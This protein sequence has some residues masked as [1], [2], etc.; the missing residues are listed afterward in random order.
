MKKFLFYILIC[1]IGLHTELI[2][3]KTDNKATK[4]PVLT[5]KYRLKKRVEPFEGAKSKGA[6][7]KPTQRTVVEGV[8]KGEKRY[9]QVP[10]VT[11]QST[12]LSKTPIQPYEKRKGYDKFISNYKFKPYEKRKGYDEF[13]S[14]YKFK[15]YEKR[16]G[17]DKFISNYKFKPYEKRRG[18]DK[19]ISNYKFKPYEKRRG[20]DKFTGKSIPYSFLAKRERIIK[21]NTRKQQSYSGNVKYVNW[22]KIRAKRSHKMAT[23]L[24]ALKIKYYPR[25]SKLSRRQ[26]QKYHKKPYNARNLRVGR[27]MWKK[28]MPRYQKYKEK[29]PK[30]NPSEKQG[31]KMKNGLPLNAEPRVSPKFIKEKQKEQKN[32]IQQETKQD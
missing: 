10:K 29:R 7:K 4:K 31:S 6:E 27:F 3:Q 13:I 15:P 26:I 30:Y 18:Y 19:F 32:K 1:L 25:K 2:A 20:Y 8:Y 16:K 22:K 24:G 28:N 14:N 9:T 5:N 17:Y 11:G 23:S 12:F 21:A